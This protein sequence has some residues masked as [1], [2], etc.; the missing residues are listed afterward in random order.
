MRSMVEG[1]LG[2]GTSR[3]LVEALR[4]LADKVP[5]LCLPSRLSGRGL[6]GGPFFRATFPRLAHCAPP[7]IARRK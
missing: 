5:S 7:A 6:R 1:L 2:E 3:R 4:G